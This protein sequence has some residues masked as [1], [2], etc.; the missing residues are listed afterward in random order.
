MPNGAL[1]ACAGML[2]A[3]LLGAPLASHATAPPFRGGLPAE[4]R[5]ARESGLLALPSRPAPPESSTTLGTT[6]ATASYTG[7]WNVPVLLVSFT[8]EPPRYEAAGFQDL[9]FDTT[10]LNPDGSLSEYY[11][12][13]SRQ[14]LRVNGSVSGWYALPHP[15]N[16]YASNAYGMKRSGTPQNIAGLVLHAVQAADPGVDF[17]QFD[18][19]ADG[20]VDVVLV[21][22]V[23]LGAEFSPSNK[24]LLWSISSGL[25][26]GWAGAQPY[27]TDDPVPGGFGQHIRVNRFAIVPELSGVRV[28]AR[29]EIGV[30]CHEFGHALGWPDLYDASTL[31][32]GA[33]LGPANWCLMSTGLYGGESLTP[34]RPTR[35]CAWALDDA[36]W[37][38][39]DNLVESGIVSFEPSDEANRVYRLW[40]EGQ[41]STEHFL[42]ENRRRRG[43]DVDLPGEGLL[44]YRVET[45]I[46]AASRGANRINSG[47]LPGLRLEEADGMYHLVS[48]QNR[49]DAGD[50]FPGRS[51]KTEVSD[52]TQPSLRT[53][54]G[55]YSNLTVTGIRP[56]D[57]RVEAWVQL[58]PTGWSEPEV[59]AIPGR[60]RLGNA[61][62]LLLYGGDWHLIYQDDLDLGRVY[63][64]QRHLGSFWGAPVAVSGSPLSSDA[65]WSVGASPLAVLWTDRRHGPPTIYYRTWR[66]SAGPEERVVTESGAFASR[67]TGAWDPSGNLHVVWLDARLGAP[68]LFWKRLRP[69]AAADSVERLVAP[70]LAGQEVL[71]FSLDASPTGNLY[72]AFTLRNADGDEVYWTRFTPSGGWTAPIRL[73]GLD[74]YPSGSPEVHVMRDSRVQILWRDLGATRNSLRSALFDTATQA[75]A[76]TTDPLF[77]T[78]LSLASASFAD[79]PGLQNVVVSRASEFPSDRVLVGHRHESGIWDAGL[80]WVSRGLEAGNH[81]VACSIEDDGTVVVVWAGLAEE[82]GQVVL[83]RRLGG[84]ASLVDVAPETP[85]FG[86]GRPVW[87]YPNP[88]SGSRVRFVVAE[89]ARGRV[90]IY[91]PTGRRVAQ[92]D[93]ARGIVTWEG[94][95]DVG[96]P[97]PPGVYLYRL[98]EGE[99]VSRAG[100][101]VWIP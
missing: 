84:S 11:E 63:A 9:L 95:D 31:G 86:D 68:Q 37:A 4:L 97:L 21:A 16:Y 46:I 94:R 1:R 19:D 3:A 14:Q 99:S 65:T 15:R 38:T 18:R 42:I 77:V 62:P 90:T 58:Q 66:P 100:K 12:T 82:S 69:G 79:G 30:Y 55:R 61:R 78:P 93:A 73:S 13:V 64:M 91:A 75:L 6:A 96:R 89:G 49:A 40:W 50:P 47:L 36:G 88:A 39:V 2:A 57:D 17:S 28:G 74:G 72:L 54:A 101:L 8:D 98:E 52:D 29:T 45:E 7:T 80:G 24:T 56:I 26:S 34:E 35:P 41:P 23:G 48:A 20:E 76:P 81:R 43:T 59:S 85:P 70:S 32:G 33:N 25:G 51:G 83:V 22:H 71:E 5:E 60:P 87:A 92:L 10:G 44:V 67:P 27:V 53:Y